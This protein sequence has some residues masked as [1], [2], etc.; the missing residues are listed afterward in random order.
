MYNRD[1]EKQILADVILYG[2]VTLGVAWALLIII[3]GIHLLIE[4][5]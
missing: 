3:G 4:N 5:L 2:L 1:K